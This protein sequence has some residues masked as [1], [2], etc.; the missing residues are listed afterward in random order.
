MPQS[1]ARSPRAGSCSVAR[2]FH[3][4]KKVSLREVLTLLNI[5][6]GGVS[7]GRTPAIGSARRVAGRL[8]GPRRAMPHQLGVRG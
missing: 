4:C 8:G 3:A 1:Q 6:A 7:Q 2:C 5:A